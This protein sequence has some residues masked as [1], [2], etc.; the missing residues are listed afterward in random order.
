MG[1]RLSKFARPS[2]LVVSLDLLEQ[3]LAAENADGLALHLVGRDELK[4]VMFGRP[5]PIVWASDATAGFDFMSWEIEEC[6][7]TAAAS[8]AGPTEPG[9]LGAA[10]ED[11]RR[12]LRKM[13]G[14]ERAPFVLGS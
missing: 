6:A 9:R 11:M 14:I 10:I 4:G 13:H 5:Y 1:F 2:T 7:L 12:Y 8:G 3:L